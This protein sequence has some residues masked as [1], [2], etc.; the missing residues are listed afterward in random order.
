MAIT[1]AGG[2]Y[3]LCWRSGQ[4]DAVNASQTFVAEEYRTDVGTLHIVGLTSLSQ[5]RT[6]ISGRRCAFD[7]MEGSMLSSGDLLMIA[8]TCGDLGEVLSYAGRG[9][10]GTVGTLNN[11]GD[12]FAS[13]ALALS[14]AGGMYRLCWCA[15]SHQPQNTRCN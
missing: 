11:S 5:D 9:L 10:L 3:R 13:T 12:A 7:D 2:Q 4:V 1:V 15:G 6:C 8:D 14:A